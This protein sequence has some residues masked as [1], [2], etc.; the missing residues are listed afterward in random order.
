MDDMDKILLKLLHENGG[1]M[2]TTEM[3][4]A[5]GIG[6]DEVVSHLMHLQEEGLVGGPLESEVLN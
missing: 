5:L 3:A 6:E 1:A 2:H 4:A